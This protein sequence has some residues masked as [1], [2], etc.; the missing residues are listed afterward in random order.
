[1]E[2]IPGELARH[3]QVP[4]GKEA[5]RVQVIVVTMIAVLC[6]SA[7]ETL[8]SAGMKEVGKGRH[9][10]L[11]FV[12]AAATDWRVLSGMVLMTAFFALYAL[13]LSWADLSFVLPLTAISY[14]VELLFA[15]FFLHESVTPTRWLG[16]LLITAGVVVVGKGG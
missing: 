15:H 3:L 2:P 6:V 16:T 4:P 10:A 12:W 1:M 8:L 7:G 9:A 14:L 11:Q 5:S 13:A